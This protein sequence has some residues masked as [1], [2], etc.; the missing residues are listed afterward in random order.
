MPLIV[1]LI[2]CFYANQTLLGLDG[3]VNNIPAGLS[4]IDGPPPG[5]SCCPLIGIAKRR[6]LGLRLH[7][8]FCP[9]SQDTPG[10]APGSLFPFHRRRN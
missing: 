4:A 2:F 7:S 1:P 8:G 3:L 9:P 5:G 6:G 10:A